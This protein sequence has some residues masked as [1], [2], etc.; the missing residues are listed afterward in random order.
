MSQADSQ[1]ISIMREGGHLLAVVRQ[2]LVDFTQVGMSFAAINAE[3]ERLIRQSGAVPN[4]SL[5]PGYHW[6]TCIMRNDEVCHGIPTE[7]KIVADGDIIMIDVGLLYKGYNLDTTTSF[8]VGDASPEVKKFLEVGKKALAA[9]IAQ[10]K[11]GNSVYE[12][13]STMQ[14]I[15]DGAGYGSVYQLTGHGIGKEL[16]E[17]P[18]IP[19]VALRADKKRKLQ[20]GQ[21]ICVEV[22]YTMGNPALYVDK[23]GWTFRTRDGKWGG[24]FEETVLVTAKGPEI[25]TK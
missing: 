2:K 9:S 5:V 24:M 20:D 12:I 11:A 17:A 18:S 10:A 4:F 8:A 14:G 19:C 15:V 25:L 7:H 1:R 6:A 3:A 13:S 21:T 23:D 22:M 16:H